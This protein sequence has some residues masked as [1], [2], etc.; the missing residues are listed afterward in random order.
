MSIR[1]VLADD[2][3]IVRQGL[4]SLLEKEPDIKVVGEAE[5]GR[6]AL[7]LVRELLPDVV[8]MDVA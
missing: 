1:I 5:D 7:H 2:H 6:K 4:R 3:E 8:V